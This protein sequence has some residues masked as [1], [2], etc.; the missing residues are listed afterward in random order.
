MER[1]SQLYGTK[2]VLGYYTNDKEWNSTNK[3]NYKGKDS[4]PSKAKF[5]RR[6]DEYATFPIN[7][8]KTVYLNK[9]EQEARDEELGVAAK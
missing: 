5:K 9:R 4:Q 6:N 7:D 2:R 1:G 8:R 3:Y